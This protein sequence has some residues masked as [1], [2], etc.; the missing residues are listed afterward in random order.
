[1]K[2]LFN[3][4]V[5]NC[6]RLWGQ[7]V[8]TYHNSDMKL[9][10]APFT[11]LCFGVLKLQSINIKY[12]PFHL[13]VIESLN[14]LGK[15]TGKYIPT[16]TYCVE[17][18]GIP[19]FQKPARSSDEKLFEYELAM[20]MPKA[21]TKTREAQEVIIS[22]AINLI[23]EFSAS[24]STSLFFPEIAIPLVHSLQKLKKMIFVLLLLNILIINRTKI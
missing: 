18:L 14:E 3:W 2:K 9:L 10:A 16:T 13:K 7:C 22:Q 4:R 21:Q 5:L 11:E 15:K 24:N 19:E 8:A 12:L 20:K 23:V 6:I 1:M 17:V